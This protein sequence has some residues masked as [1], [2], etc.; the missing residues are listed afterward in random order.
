[1][2]AEQLAAGAGEQ[3]RVADLAVIVAAQ[4]RAPE[5]DPVPAGHAGEPDLKVTA[6]MG[7]AF[8]PS[9]DITTPELLIRYADEALYQAKK[10]GRNTICLYQAQ[11]YRYD[12]EPR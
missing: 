6:S 12:A 8:Y 7:I 3:E 11:A 4:E 2:A 5:P 1:M 9:K 10:A